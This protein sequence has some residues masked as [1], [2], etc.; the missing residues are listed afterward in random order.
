MKLRSPIDIEADYD[1][2]VL[3]EV[4]NIDDVKQLLIDTKRLLK[5]EKE[6]LTYLIDSG[7]THITEAIDR[8]IL[9]HQEI[10]GHLSKVVKEK[11]RGAS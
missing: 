8:G 7:Q 9:R 5:N 3:D 1:N 11:K 10:T 4:L 2:V 6:Y